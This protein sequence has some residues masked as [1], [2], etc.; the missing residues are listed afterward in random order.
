MVELFKN[1]LYHL[2]A[3]EIWDYTIKIALWEK[4]YAKI[5]DTKLISQL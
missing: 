4:L 3:Q 5:K 2:I 1:F